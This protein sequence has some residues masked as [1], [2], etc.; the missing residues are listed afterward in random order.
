[1]AISALELRG[2]TLRPPLLSAAS[3][4]VAL[5]CLL[6]G[7]AVRHGRAMTSTPSLHSKFHQLKH[8]NIRIPGET[9][10]PVYDYFSLALFLDASPCLET[11][12]LRIHIAGFYPAKSLL[13]LAC[14]VLETATSLERLELGTT[15]CPYGFHNNNHA[16]C[17]LVAIRTYIDKKVPSTVRLDVRGPCTGSRG[18][19]I[20]S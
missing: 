2:S 14:Y 10:G 19:R 11:L 12:I 5:L 6:Q 8:L 9:H 17:Y 4:V 13:E 15:Y 1:M 18:F 3:C 7:A 16:N 20:L